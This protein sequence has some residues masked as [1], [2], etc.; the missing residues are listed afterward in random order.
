MI[1]AMNV[2]TVVIATGLVAILE[3]CKCTGTYMLTGYGVQSEHVEIVLVTD[4]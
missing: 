1:S 3:T 4:P 2:C